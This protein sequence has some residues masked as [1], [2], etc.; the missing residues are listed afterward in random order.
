MQSAGNISTSHITAFLEITLKPISA[1]FYKNCPN[2]FGQDS[3]QYTG[4]LL[5]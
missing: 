3:R 5:V 4:D 1:D 2:E